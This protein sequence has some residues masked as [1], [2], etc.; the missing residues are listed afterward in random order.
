[1]LSFLLLD[2]GLAAIGVGLTTIGA[3]IGI[4]MLTY[5]TAEPIFHLSQNPDKLSLTCIFYFIMLIN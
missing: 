4:G 1:M 3:G 2:I 5:S